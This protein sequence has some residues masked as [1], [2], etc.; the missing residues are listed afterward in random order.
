MYNVLVKLDKE[1]AKSWKSIPFDSRAEVLELA[2]EA[3]GCKVDTSPRG[4]APVYLNTDD[5]G[6]AQRLYESGPAILANY[7]KPKLS[8]ETEICKQWAEMKRA[9]GYKVLLEITCPVGRTD[10]ILTRGYEKTVVEAKKA[11][12][13]KHALG[14][15]LCYSYYYT[16]YKLALLLIGRL[17]EKQE[18]ICEAICKQF[19]VDVIWYRQS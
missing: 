1:T 18:R 5:Y 10:V 19:D 16:G 9:E 3:W 12:R 7:L 14:Q 2:L 13:W 8:Y 4:N 11:K 6:A 15:V 17:T